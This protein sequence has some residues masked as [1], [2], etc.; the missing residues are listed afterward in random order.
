MVD[1]IRGWGFNAAA[2]KVDGVMGDKGVVGCY[3][4][5]GAAIEDGSAGRTVVFI[6]RGDGAGTD[7]VVMSLAGGGITCACS[8][9]C[10]LSLSCNLMMRSQNGMHSHMAAFQHF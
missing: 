8:E 4:G 6:G 9:R 1:G 7:G 3:T 5:D 10:R 2:D